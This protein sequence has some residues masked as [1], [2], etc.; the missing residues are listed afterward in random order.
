MSQI[1]IAD[2][3]G[4]LAALVERARGGEDVTLAEGGHAVARIVPVVE[5]DAAAIAWPGRGRL[6]MPPGKGTV[7]DEPVHHPVTLGRLA[8]RFQVPDDFDRPLPDDL[9]DLFEGK[10]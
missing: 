8:G 5:R 9:L 4:D 7:L 10:P 2:A 3:A 1:E 6:G